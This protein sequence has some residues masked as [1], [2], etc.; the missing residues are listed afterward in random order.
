MKLPALLAAAALLLARL[1][2]A[3]YE[4]GVF[5][6]PDGGKL[7][8]QI[9]KPE[10]YDAAKKYPLVIFLHGSGDR[11]DDNKAQLK[12]GGSLF[13]GQDVREKFP[14]FVIFP[15]CPRDQKWVE[16][17][18]S[19]EAPVAPADPG[20]TQKLLIALIDK[21]A[22]EFSIDPDRHYL[23]GLSMGGFGTWDLIVRH[24]GRWAAAAPICGGGDKTKAA[25]AKGIPVWAFHGDADGVVKVERT[26]EMVAALKAANGSVA[27]TIYPGVGHNSWSLAFAEA[28]FLPWMFA[29][30]RGQAAQKMELAVSPLTALAMPAENAFPGAGPLQVGEWFKN[31]WLKRRTGFSRNVAVEKGAIVFLGDSITQGWGS[32]A[33]DF[34]GMKVANRGIS[35]DTARGVRYRLRGDVLDLNPKAVSILIGTNDLALGGEPQQVIDNIKAIV[36]ELQK[37]NPE[38]P[39]I[40][41]R[42]MPRGPSPGKF[43]EKI[44]QLNGMIDAMVAADAHLTVCDTWGIF[45]DGKGSC[46][47]EEFPDMLHPNKAGYAK[48][49]TALTDVFAK[50]KL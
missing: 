11:G 9:L 49:K 13:P 44:Q 14:A 31:L 33:E 12:W 48:W 24:P 41:N 28:N 18:W 7:P 25:A 35:G 21:V 46:K 8:Y 23:T 39:I 42:V 1:S 37:Q 16:I 32:L 19:V 20:A 43:P 2:A 36:A 26:I 38:I 17:G 6:A 4:A 50:L 5:T 22:G 34:P 27:Q 30:R 45:D 29:Q 47:K 40:L 15:Q 3:D 10:N